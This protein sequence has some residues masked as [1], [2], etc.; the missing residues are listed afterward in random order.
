VIYAWDEGEKVTQALIKAGLVQKVS[1]LYYA[2]DT[3]LLTKEIAGGRQWSAL[4][5]DYYGKV[6]VNSTDPK[7]SNSGLLFFGLMANAL[8]GNVVTLADLQDPST[9]IMSAL[10]TIYNDQGNMEKGSEKLFQ[11]FLQTGAGTYPMIALYESELQ[12]YAVSHPEQLATLRSDFRIL[13]PSPTVWSEHVL[14][15]LTPGGTRLAEALSDPDIQRIA[16]EKHGFRTGLAGGTATDVSAFQ[17]LN[18]PKTIDK[19]T[20]VPRPDAMT[21]MKDNL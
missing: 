19:V 12:E 17:L 16:W 7:S 20:P 5:V 6:K 21:Y 15:A 1:N 9:N 4:G 14:I 13:Y 18:I 11:A 8:K 3:A 10:R 2:V